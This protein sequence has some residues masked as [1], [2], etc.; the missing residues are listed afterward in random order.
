MSFLQEFNGI[1]PSGS[2]CFKSWKQ[3]KVPRDPKVA[4]DRANQEASETNLGMVPST[5]VAVVL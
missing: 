5:G 1:Y 2:E 4:G 3:G